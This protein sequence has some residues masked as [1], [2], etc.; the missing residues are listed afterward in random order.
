MLQDVDASVVT[1]ALM[2]LEELMLPQ[3]G[4]DVTQALI[5]SLLNRISEFNEWGLNLILDSLVPRYIPASE[6]ETFGIMNI[7]DPLLRTSNSGTVLAVVKCF[8]SLTKPFP[9]FQAQVFVRAKTPMLTLITGGAPEIQYSIFKHIETMLSRPICKGVFDEDFRS[10][11]VRYNE[12]PHLKHLKVDLL[13]LVVNSSNAVDIAAELGE[14]VTDVDAELSKRAIRAIGKIAVKIPSVSSDMTQ[15]LTEI[16]DL[17]VPY[18]R[19]ESIK[20]LVVVLRTFPAMRLHVIP[21]LSRYLRRI[22]NPEAR[23]GLIW[24]LG[25]YAT[26]IVEAPYMLEKIIDKYS[27][28]I[29]T[30][31]KLQCLVAAMKM[32]FQR[33]PEVHAMLGRLLDVAVNDTSSQDLHDRALLY[34]R[35]LSSGNIDVVA[36]MFPSSRDSQQDQVQ[37]QDAQGRAEGIKAFAEDANVEMMGKVFQEFNT[38]SIVYNKPSNQFIAEKYQQ[39]HI[40]ICICHHCLIFIL[41]Q[42]PSGDMSY[43]SPLYSMTAQQVSGP[44]PNSAVTSSNPVQSPAV[45]SRSKAASVDLLDMGGSN[46]LLAVV[47]SVST[48]SAR[49][50]LF[51]RQCGGGGAGDFVLTPQTFQKMWTS[52]PEAY[53]GRMCSLGKIL[54]EPSQIESLVGSVQV[55][56][57]Q[58]VF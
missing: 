41:Q 12:P 4:I 51:L 31:I 26:E 44:P 1:N 30:E 7:L 48:Q 39:V 45:D 17:D 28:E 18:V 32:F 34:Y 47:N 55:I 54:A 20:T 56:S 53:S 58:S 33:P 15:R 24:M 21:S 49:P 10:F 8:I 52:L 57:S 37:M 27:E 16:V 38:L 22:E 40:C 23:S 19:E 35:L 11:F 43:E 25:E 46:D 14:Y 3:G 42:S 6:E 29:S 9:D 5:L 36:S 2:V 50:P 13:P